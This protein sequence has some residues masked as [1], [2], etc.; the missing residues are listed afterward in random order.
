MGQW[1]KE[2]IKAFADKD[3]RISKLAIV[4]SLIEKLPLED[5]YEVEKIT[6]LAEK[7]IDYV[8]EE[9]RIA[10]RGQVASVG[11]DTKH[12]PNWE[13]VAIGLNLAIPNS[14][15]VKILN[16]ILDEY[17]K[18][19]KASANPKDVL[20]CC[21]DKFGTYPTKSSSVEKVVKQLLKG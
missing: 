9:R 19:Y 21:I 4:K 7:Y 15:N 5:A 18:A 12:E 14:Q 2:E 1:T 13:Q 10:K 11:D 17:K 6:E 20:V 8:Y 3:L 16:Q